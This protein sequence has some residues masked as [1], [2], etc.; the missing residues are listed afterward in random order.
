MR[1]S[2]QNLCTTFM[3]GNQALARTAIICTHR[4][5][6]NRQW[7]NSRCTSSYSLPYLRSNITKPKRSNLY[8]R[9]MRPYVSY[10]HCSL[11]KYKQVLNL[12]TQRRKCTS[13]TMTRRETS[14]RRRTYYC[15][16]LQFPTF[17]ARTNILV[18][19]QHTREYDEPR[20]SRYTTLSSISCIVRAQEP[21]SGF[22]L[23]MSLHEGAIAKLKNA[24]TS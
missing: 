9:S 22:T 11:P 4:Q 23:S 20:E 13:K 7:Q 6:A 24:S 17:L 18:S 3:S 5:V 16:S 2:W 1:P 8:L 10:Q 21:T 12:L 14:A 15:S 19:Y